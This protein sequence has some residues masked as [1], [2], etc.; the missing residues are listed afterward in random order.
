[1]FVYLFDKRQGINTFVCVCVCVCVCVGGGGGRSL[2]KAPES[3]SSVARYAFNSF[4][5]VSSKRLYDIHI[6]WF[7]RFVRRKGDSVALQ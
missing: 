3:V 4:F 1:M 6:T 5:F 2:E 7:D